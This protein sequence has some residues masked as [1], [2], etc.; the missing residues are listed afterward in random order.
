VREPNI[1][2]L[3]LGS[4]SIAPV[5][6]AP[7]AEWVLGHIVP[8]PSLRFEFP[9][10]EPIDFDFE[11]LRASFAALCRGFEAVAVSSRMNAGA[12]RNLRLLFPELGRT[13]YVRSIR[14]DYR[15][16]ARARVRARRH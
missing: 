11:A 1:L 6:T 2:H 10:P 14:T 13:A 9:R 16:R 15:R 7:P 8:G 3:G 12:F 5:D 4:V